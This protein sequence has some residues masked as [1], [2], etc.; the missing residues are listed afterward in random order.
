MAPTKEQHAWLANGAECVSGWQIQ[1]CEFALYKPVV[2]LPFATHDKLHTE[3]N[4]LFLSLIPQDTCNN[5][6]KD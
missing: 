1:L 3:S 2:I 5:K 4:H 6:K